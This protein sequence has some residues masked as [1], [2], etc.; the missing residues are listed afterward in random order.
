MR[1]KEVPEYIDRTTGRTVTYMTVCNWVN[2][3][4]RGVKLRAIKGRSAA[5][6]ALPGHAAD[7]GGVDR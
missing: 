5:V 2:K 3:G 7:D 4:V 6:D 1:L